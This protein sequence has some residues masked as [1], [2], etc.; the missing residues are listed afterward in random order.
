MPVYP[1]YTA[2]N[3]NK[4]EFF[5]A[6]QSVLIV[7]K[8]CLIKNQIKIEF[9]KNVSNI[10]DDGCIPQINLSLAATNS[11]NNDKLISM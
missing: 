2:E 9:E 11:S 1:Y 6:M 3:R 5:L 7:G 8:K 4:D 10:F